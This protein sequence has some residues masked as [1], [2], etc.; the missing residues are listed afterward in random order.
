MSVSVGSSSATYEGSDYIYYLSQTRFDNVL[1]KLMQSQETGLKKALKNRFHDLPFPENF[2]TLG[3]YTFIIFLWPSN[4]VLWLFVTNGN[5]FGDGWRISEAMV[6]KNVKLVVPLDKFKTE[7]LAVDGK[8]L[9]IKKE[10]VD[11]EM[12]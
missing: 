6:W 4:T 2:D 8:H 11:G 7:F 3:S 1:K 9:E 5:S 12:V 10:V